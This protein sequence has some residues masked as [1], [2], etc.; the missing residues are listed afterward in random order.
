M[1]PPWHRQPITT[2]ERWGLA[3][4]L[5]ERSK[6][7]RLRLMLTVRALPLHRTLALMTRAF[8]RTRGP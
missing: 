5:G 1:F 7:H 4:G 2:V 3:H 6:L 8:P